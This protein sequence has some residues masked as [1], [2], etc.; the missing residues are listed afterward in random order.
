MVFVLTMLGC[1]TA[2]HVRS[3]CL[4]FSVPSQRLRQTQSERMMSLFEHAAIG[5]CEA[6]YLLARSRLL[7]H[8]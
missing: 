4:R 7:Q 8:P 1:T 6:I 5:M 3:G 2:V